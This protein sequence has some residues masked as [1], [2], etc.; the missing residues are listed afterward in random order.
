MIGWIYVE[1]NIPSSNKQRNVNRER[2]KKRRT[3]T[4]NKKKKQEKKFVNNDCTSWKQFERIQRHCDNTSWMCMMLLF[5][6]NETQIHSSQLTFVGW[7][8]FWPE[9]NQTIY[10]AVHFGCHVDFV[11][12][13]TFCFVT[14][15]SN[16]CLK[17]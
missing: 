12:A 5:Q 1:V 8:P 3:N 17:M 13:T 10:D 11:V 9:R 15:K 16:R 2:E 7:K 14:K 6:S 4:N